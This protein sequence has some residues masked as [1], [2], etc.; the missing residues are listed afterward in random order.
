MNE[1]EKTDHIATITELAKIL[2]NAKT[3]FIT[4]EEWERHKHDCFLCRQMFYGD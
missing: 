1:Q 3:D 4:D 2:L